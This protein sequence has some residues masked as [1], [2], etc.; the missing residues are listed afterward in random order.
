MKNIKLIGLIAGIA[1]LLIGLLTPLPEGM[2]LAARNVGLVSI[3]MAIWWMTEAIPIYATAFL[4]M[5]LYPLLGILPAGETAINYG[6]DFV[7][8]MISGFFLAKAIEAQNLH[9]RIALV[10]IKTLGTSRPIILLSIML[11]TAFMSMWIANVTAALLMLP[12]GLALVVKEEELSGGRSSFG[13]VLMLGIAFSAS[14]GGTATL[15]GSPTNMIF[16]G[17]LTKM[18]P[19]AP[20]IS[21][22]T[23]MKIG[24]P[25]VVI[26]LP[27]VWFY[28]VR[29]YK[30]KDSMPGSKEMMR[31]ELLAMGKYV[32]RRKP[33]FGYFYFDYNRL[34][35]QRRYRD[36]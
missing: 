11:A 36:R 35:F 23:W 26:F 30:V 10:I 20:S 28:L 6:H 14:I 1:I 24:L 16:S 33:C 8:M 13:T 22:F 25:L 27:L 32:Q 31:N 34:D 2:S 29:L 17:V 5:A 12:I 21:F 18:F 7:L 19:L 15:I 4:P 9:K 3:L